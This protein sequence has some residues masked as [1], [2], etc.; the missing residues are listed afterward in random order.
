MYGTWSCEKR[1]KN[2]G[3]F[4][5]RGT[6]KTIETPGTFKWARL[7][8]KTFPF[9]QNADKISGPKRE[10]RGCSEE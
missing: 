9:V 5:V 7:R 8:C 4:L 2:V 3:N 10:R 1:D 6:F